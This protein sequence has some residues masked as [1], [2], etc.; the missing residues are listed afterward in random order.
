M[1]TKL[2][3]GRLDASHDG[4]TGK[5]LSMDLQYD[6]AVHLKNYGSGRRSTPTRL[7]LFLSRAVPHGGPKSVRGREPVEVR[8]LDGNKC[9]VPCPRYYQFPDL[10]TCRAHWDAN[11]GGPYTW[12]AVEEMPSGQ[13]PF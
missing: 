3:A 11:F 7:G 5:V 6:F 1:E 9:M 12:P 8:M 2:Q 13:E 10:D 4:W